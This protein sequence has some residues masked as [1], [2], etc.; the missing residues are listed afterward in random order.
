M[1]REH[2]QRDEA[3]VVA[4]Q[5]GAEWQEY[6]NDGHSL[7]PQDR[8]WAREEACRLMDNDFLGVDILVER[9]WTPA[10][11]RTERQSG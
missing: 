2:Q 9:D 3:L 7:C 4:F 6:M 11:P 8:E 10:P 1:T 5:Q